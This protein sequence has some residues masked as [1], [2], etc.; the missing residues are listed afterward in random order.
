MSSVEIVVLTNGPGELYTWAGPMLRALRAARED[1]RIVLG[2][3]PCPFASGQELRIA[4]ELGF[5]AV[6]TVAENLAFMAGGP[7]PTAFEGSRTHAS[8]LVLGLGGDVAFPGRIASRLGYPAWRYSFEPYWKDSLEHLFVHDARTLGKAQRSGPKDR[9]E[10]IGNLV[11]DAL[12]AEHAPS[13]PPG[14][15]VLVMAGSRRFEVEH[16]LPLFAAAVE[17]ITATLAPGTTGT[18]TLAPGTTGTKTVPNVRFH[19]PRS[20]LLEDSAIHVALSGRKVQDVGGVPTRLEDGGS[21]EQ[22][23]VTPS[24]AR[25]RVALEEERYGLMKIADLALTIPGTNTLELGIARVPSIVCLPLQKMELIPIENPLRYL[26]L[27]PGVGPAIKRKLV[28]TALSRFKFVALPNMI[29][30]EAIQPELRGQV[31]PDDIARAS[32]HL[33]E[34]GSERERIRSRLTA[35]M[36]GPGAAARLAARILERLRLE[37]SPAQERSRNHA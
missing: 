14:L 18:A 35:T 12:E 36:P 25:I 9:I 27:I 24:G 37:L 7:K 29:S 6:S 19:W 32:I 2:L 5:D 20:R 31:T 17:G 10:M 23:L 28:E 34:N 15:D 11:A 3:L 13:K 16:M 22:C 33:L 4:R 1:L 8:G 30:D 21:G 26:G